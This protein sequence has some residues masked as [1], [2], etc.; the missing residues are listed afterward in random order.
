[1]RSYIAIIALCSLIVVGCADKEK[2]EALQKQL[3]QAQSDRESA[4]RLL[5]ERD[6]YLEGVMKEIND[7]YADVE[8]ARV[9]EG[10][11][12]RKAQ[13]VEASKQTS[14]L[15]SRKQLLDN[16][17]DIGAVLKDSRTRVASLQSRVKSL[18]VKIAAL[19]TLIVSLKNTIA[20][21]EEAIALLQGR[22]QGLEVTVAE[23]TA[24]IA[25]RDNQLAEQT[26][27]MN[28]VFYIA[29]T[30][31]ELEEKGIIDEEGGFL[32]GLL[33]STTVVAPKADPH[34]FTALDRT[35]DNTI[36]INGEIDE[37]LPH[38]ESALFAT[39]VEENAG[40]DLKILEP[41][42]FWREQYLVVVLD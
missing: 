40:S 36:H 7:I 11:I 41:D 27:K 42:K 35:K 30:R 29:G 32:W 28:K 8:K 15:D 10:T 21:R 18:G 24:T 5:N 26:R 31:A 37:I 25:E 13:G 4:Q 1:M 34:E 39:T 6:L 14:N 9:K 3:A 22:V 12:T 33:G 17:Q 19:D 23:K 38:R 2:E 20:E 16:I